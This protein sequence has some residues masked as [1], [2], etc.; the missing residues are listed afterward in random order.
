MKYTGSVKH[1]QKPEAERVAIQESAVQSYDKPSAGQLPGAS[2]NRAL[3]SQ[4]QRS[5]HILALQKTIGNR[6]VMRMLA[7]RPTKVST[8]IQ[9][10]QSGEDRTKDITLAKSLFDGFL[11]THTIGQH[12]DPKKNQAL[13]EQ[14]KKKTFELFKFGLK[15]ES[16]Q[17]YWLQ[18]GLSLINKPMGQLPDIPENEGKAGKTPIWCDQATAIVIA[19]LNDKAEFK[20]SLQVVKQGDPKQH[21]HW[22]VIAN[23]DPKDGPPKYGEDLKGSEFIIDIWG[24]LRLNEYRAAEKEELLTSIVFDQKAPYVMDTRVLSENEQLISATSE[25][26][27]A[28][29]EKD[30]LTEVL[31]DMEGSKKTDTSAL[32]VEDIVKLLKEKVAKK[33]EQQ[34][35]L[36]SPVFFEE[37]KKVKLDED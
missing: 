24:A 23:R 30:M 32:S 31:H 33:E 20:S 35:K 5:S 27:L 37:G 25:K 18:K 14:A 36:E 13:I 12:I 34:T 16:N 8:V 15:G 11:G 28:I 22:Y 7:H 4:A 2:W 21:G 10:I 19:T 26:D 6:A 1:P 3:T 29:Y 9:R 17:Q